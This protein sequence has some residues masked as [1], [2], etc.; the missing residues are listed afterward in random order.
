LA[1]V[2]T[3]MAQEAKADSAVASRGSQRPDSV[4]P[5]RDWNSQALDALFGIVQD[6]GSDLKA[7]RK[8]A[9][10]IAEFL[11]PKTAK[12]AK[13]LPDEYGFTVYPNLAT[14]YR[15]IQLEIRSLVN[16][17]SR[18][19]PASAEKLNKLEARA[20]AIRR[21]L[22]VPCP[23]KYGLK[24]V[25]D[26]QVRLNAFTGLRDDKIALSEERN[27][28]EAHRKVRYDVFARSPEP[29]ARRRRQALEAAE[30]RFN[31]GRTT[32]DF[33]AP[34]LSR[35][36]RNDLKLLRWLYPILKSNDVQLETEI[37][38]RY[39]PF[40]HELPASDGNFYPPDSKLRPASASA[41]DSAADDL[42]ANAVDG[43]PVV[44]VNISNPSATAPS[45][46]GEPTLIANASRHNMQ[47]AS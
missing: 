38:D 11:L 36:D 26:D 27:A 1:G 45:E 12:K 22:Q 42:P 40:L 14:Q 9:L 24:E 20:E 35:K 43:P 47:R 46:P 4:P 34:R 37:I 31:Q 23:T 41:A 5:I 39:H 10:K 28:E 33:F 8:A 25:A 21:R 19:M 15:D 16:H 18:I 17:P 30:R 7:R 3:T 13:A 44:P 2:R 32:A 6:A 29:V